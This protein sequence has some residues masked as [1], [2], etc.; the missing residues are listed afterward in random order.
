MTRRRA[1][2]GVAGET[3]KEFSGVV[4]LHLRLC[5]HAGASGEVINVFWVRRVHAATTSSSPES[6]LLRPSEPAPTSV[7]L[8]RLY[9][10]RGRSLRSPIRCGF[11]IA[12]GSATCGSCRSRSGQRHGIIALSHECL[13]R[14]RSDINSGLSICVAAVKVC[15]Q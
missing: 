13:L 10:T 12:A 2:T 8:L 3:K 14:Q 9:V 11:A 15:F 6:T 5:S 1:R 4:S 7:S